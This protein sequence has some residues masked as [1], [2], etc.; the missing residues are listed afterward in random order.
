MPEIWLRYGITDVVLDIRFENLSS[1]ISSTFPVISDEQA[2]AALDS[3]PVT[4]N[5]LIL[6]LAS[7]KATAKVIASIFDAAKAK[8]FAANSITVDVSAKTA[9]ALR[10]N[11]AAI[12]SDPQNTVQ[13]PSINRIDY[14]SLEERARK[15]QSI[16][17]VSRAG[18]DPLFGFSGAPTELV[19]TLFP[20][21]M[22][23]AFM[24]RKE[25]NVPAPGEE[26]EPLKIAISAMQDISGSAVELVA[27]GTG[28]AGVHTGTIQGA[29]S[30]AVEQLKAIATLEAD[31]VRSAFI[32]AGN[33]AGTHS[34][35]AGALYSLWNTVHIVR[36]G[37]SA[38]LLAECRDGIGGGALQAFVEGRLKQEQLAGTGDMQYIDGLEHLLYM[39]GMRQKC[40]LGL[41]SSL[42]HYYAGAKLGFTTYASAR[43]ALEKLLVRNGKGHKA[44]V[45][46]DADITLLRPKV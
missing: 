15:F 24:A 23:E 46:S 4:D 13:M 5:M 25:G 30:K 43:D 20:E 39:Q 32:S 26:G 8:G 36:E 29:F 12:A 38:V 41:V 35:L 42:P 31:P 2:K 37:G 34:T 3:V 11:L 6:A 27:N 28:I 33:E 1:Q 22:A 21:K 16:V 18:F 10:A 17:V 14:Q 7:S 19:R 9:S 40:E 45:I 44:L